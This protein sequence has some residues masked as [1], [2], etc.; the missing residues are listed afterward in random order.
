MGGDEANCPV[1]HPEIK[2]R[3]Q[4]LKTEKVRCYI[5]KLFSNVTISL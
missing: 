5:L 3:Q 1:F 4:V 2:S